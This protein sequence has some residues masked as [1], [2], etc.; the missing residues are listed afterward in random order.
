LRPGDKLL[1]LDLQPLLDQ[2]YEMGGYARR[3][4]YKQPPDPPLEEN[5]D[6]WAKALLKDRA[7]TR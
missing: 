5:D 4:T 6:A 1:K 2:A 7:R 3:L